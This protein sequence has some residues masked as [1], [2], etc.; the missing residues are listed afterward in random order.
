MQHEW[1]DDWISWCSPILYKTIFGSIGAHAVGIRA[2][3]IPFLLEE[4]ARMDLPYDVGPLTAATRAMPSYV[5]YPN[6]A[7]QRLDTSSDIN[8]SGF[9]A[10]NSTEAVSRKFRWALGDYE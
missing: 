8:S 3:A 4:I 6:I 5:I 1:S 10:A 9:I 7:I 2:E